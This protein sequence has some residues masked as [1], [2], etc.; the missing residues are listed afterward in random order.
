MIFH[1]AR[2]GVAPRIEKTAPASPAEVF[3]AGNERAI[4]IN[5]T[6]EK[7]ADL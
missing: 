7:S 4:M 6:H 2:K 5:V 3:I 1:P